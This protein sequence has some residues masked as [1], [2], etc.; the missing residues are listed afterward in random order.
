MAGTPTPAAL[1]VTDSADYFELK[2]SARLAHIKNQFYR[3]KTG[4]LFQKTYAPP[5]AEHPDADGETYFKGT[6]PQDLD[7]FTFE[8]IDGSWFAK[9]KNFVYN[10]RPTDAGMV[11]IKIKD[12]NVKHFKLLPGVTGGRHGADD[13][14]VFEEESI[15]EN[16]N[17][18]T[19]RVI[20]DKDGWLKEII[21]GHYVYLA[22][23]G[24]TVAMPLRPR[25]R[26]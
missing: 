1:P 15:I 24:K 5:P 9:D 7:P 13:R 19:M 8:V 20:T 16:I 4:R 11:C 26:S 23:S 14:H 18:K 21:S 10:Y 3:S 25:N 12:A 2:D 6:I 22:D 17:P